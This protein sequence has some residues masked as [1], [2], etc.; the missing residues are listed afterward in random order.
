MLRQ[1]RSGVPPAFTPP[2]P[3]AS[4]PSSR[5]CCCL[6]LPPP[7]GPGRNQ[8]AALRARPPTSRPSNAAATWSIDPAP[9]STR[10]FPSSS[11]STKATPM[12]R[13]SSLRVKGCSRRALAPAGAAP[14][15]MRA[16]SWSPPSG[17][18]SAKGRL[19]ITRCHSRG[20]CLALC[21]QCGGGG[22]GGVCLFSQARQ[23]GRQVRGKAGIALPTQ[24]P[25]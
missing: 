21:M 13:P 19:R 17:V 8:R 24:C 18:Q 3:Y 20:C 14:A 2:R 5:C 12:G 10:P 16:R 7:R 1:K 22:S 23:A 6:V 4:S 11:S 9:T 15:S 25:T